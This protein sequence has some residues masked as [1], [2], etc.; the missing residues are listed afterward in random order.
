M[1]NYLYDVLFYYFDSS[2]RYFDLIILTFNYFNW[3]LACMRTSIPKP[4]PKKR[5]ATSQSR[6]RVDMKGY[7]FISNYEI[8]PTVILFL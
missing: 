2:S 6:P 3:K 1:F 4:I 8:K 7:F 5:E